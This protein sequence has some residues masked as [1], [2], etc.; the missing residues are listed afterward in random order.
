VGKTPPGS[1][2]L[3]LQL[4]QIY[5]GWRK[6]DPPTTQQL[7]VKADVPELLAEK[8]RDSSATELERVI[9]NLSIIAFYYLLRIGEYTVKGQRNVKRFSS[10]IRI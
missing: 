5:N 8:G 6:E 10:N 3:L 1:E 4:S 2:K 7:P 9:G